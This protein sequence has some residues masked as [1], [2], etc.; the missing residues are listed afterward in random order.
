MKIFT[1]PITHLELKIV[2]GF[3][4]IESNQEFLPSFEFISHNNPFKYG[5]I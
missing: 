2:V 3:S 1:L 5:E 4:K